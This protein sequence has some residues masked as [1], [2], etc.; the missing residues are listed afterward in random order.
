MK[1]VKTEELLSR[2]SK[3]Y[4]SPQYAFLSQVRN[5]TG[6]SSTVRTA[7]ALALSLWP[8]RG[9]HLIGF[10]LKVSR[11]DWLHELKDPAKAEAIAQ[12]CDMFY[13]V[14]SDSKVIDIAEVPKTWGVL[15]ASNGTVKTLREA[16]LLEAKA[17][18]RT[19]LCGF[20]RNVDES[21]ARQYTPTVEV[22]KIIEER[23]ESGL[24]ARTSSLKYESERY[25]K[26][27]ENL[28]KFRD[29]SGLDLEKLE[30]NW[31]DPVKL[32]EAV[33]IVMNN[34][35][36]R[37]IDDLDF[38]KSRVKTILDNINTQLNGLEDFVAGRRD[39]KAP[40]PPQE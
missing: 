23:V 17:M 21:I 35:I 3:K 28:G 22:S 13:L 6:H 16:P 31:T 19:F 10:E 12:Y 2:L 24:D 36:D 15:V 9:N 26:L 32:G 14:I 30:Y 5:Q 33:H 29:A 37:I 27:V 18:D 4:P 40:L 25:K 34:D 7:D 38:T 1:R 8:S 11:S 39:S 20:M